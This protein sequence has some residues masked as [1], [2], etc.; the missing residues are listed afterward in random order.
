MYEPDEAGAQLL[1]VQVQ[2]ILN[3]CNIRSEEADKIALYK[4]TWTPTHCATEQ[5]LG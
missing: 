4:S 2:A 1:Q 5:F 3:D